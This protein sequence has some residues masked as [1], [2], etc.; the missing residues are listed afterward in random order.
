MGIQA[1]L[2]ELFATIQG[3]ALATMSL[4]IR[5]YAW[6]SMDMHSHQSV[7][8]VSWID[9]PKTSICG[10]THVVAVRKHCLRLTRS[11]AYPRNEN[12][13][14]VVLGESAS[15]LDVAARLIL[16]AVAILLPLRLDGAPMSFDRNLFQH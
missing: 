4:S 14:V 8:I 3:H 12:P 1:Y 5:R 11:L 13:K 7:L 16:L 2:F 10:R 9:K 15:P 6:K